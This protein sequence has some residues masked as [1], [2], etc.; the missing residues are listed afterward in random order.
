MTKRKY[1]R[2]ETKTT[3][4]PTEAPAE[5]KAVQNANTNAETV[6]PAPAKLYKVVLKL[7]IKDKEIKEVEYI[8]KTREVEY[9]YPDMKTAQVN[10]THIAT[11]MRPTLQNQKYFEAQNFGAKCELIEGW[12][13]SDVTEV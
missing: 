8:C 6:Q 11:S 1:V 2:K 5:L 7:S 13:I 10:R 12:D 4:T 9:I 3:I